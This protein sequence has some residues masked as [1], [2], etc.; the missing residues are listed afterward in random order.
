MKKKIFVIALLMG[1]MI[2]FETEAAGLRQVI[3]RLFG[4]CVSK[5]KP[6]VVTRALPIETLVDNKAN[7]LNKIAN[8]DFRYK[9]TD[10][11]KVEVDDEKDFLCDEMNGIHSKWIDWFHRNSLNSK[12]DFDDSKSDDSKALIEYKK[13][14]EHAESFG[15]APVVDFLNKTRKFAVDSRFDDAMVTLESKGYD[16]SKEDEKKEYDAVYKLHREAADDLLENRRGD[17]QY[18]PNDFS[19]K[20]N[21]GMVVFCRE[22]N[23]LQGGINAKTGGSVPL[24]S[25]SE[26]FGKFVIATKKHCVDKER[27]HDLEVLRK[28]KARKKKTKWW[29]FSKKKVGLAIALG[30]AWFLSSNYEIDFTAFEQSEND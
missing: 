12:V 4:R 26:H 8:R 23:D 29:N 7:E 19:K 5:K 30:S 28:F 6:F 3:G 20:F 27:N 16:K 21:G 2:S 10:F 25:P 14:L 11:V 17:F 1:F 22:L 13:P 9:A 15:K 18:Q 24:A